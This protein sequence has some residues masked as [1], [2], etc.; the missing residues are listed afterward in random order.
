MD[1]FQRIRVVFHGQ[2]KIAL[3]QNDCYSCLTVRQYD[4][5]SKAA[6][7]AVKLFHPCCSQWGG[8][9]TL[10]SISF[11]H[12]RDFKLC[13]G[14]YLPAVFLN[15]ESSDICL[16]HD[17]NKVS[18]WWNAPTQCKIILWLKGCSTCNVKVNEFCHMGIGLGKRK[19]IRIKDLLFLILGD[20]YADRYNVVFVTLFQRIHGYFWNIHVQCST[21]KY[22]IPYS[23]SYSMLLPVKFRQGKCCGFWI[24]PDSVKMITA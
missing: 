4:T 22:S 8:W 15:F 23:I 3:F 12:S 20:L 24:L 19:L 21:N 1:S 7:A 9:W 17:T 16:K 2:A 11:S 18:F 13:H 14:K 5:Q 10:T 6:A